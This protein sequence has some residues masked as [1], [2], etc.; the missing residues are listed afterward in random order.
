MIKLS[1]I[2]HL[3]PADLMKAFC[4]SVAYLEMDNNLLQMQINYYETGDTPT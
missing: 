4:Q 3:V 1:A 2:E